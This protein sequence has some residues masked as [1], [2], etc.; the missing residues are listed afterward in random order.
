MAQIHRQENSAEEEPPSS[1]PAAVQ[2]LPES[3]GATSAMRPESNRQTN[4][5]EDRPRGEGPALERQERVEQKPRRRAPH[6]PREPGRVHREHQAD[7]E[8]RAL[9]EAKRSPFPDARREKEKQ[10]RRARAGLQRK[11]P[12][13]ESAMRRRFY[14]VAAAAL[15]LSA[16][17]PT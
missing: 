12:R 15:T 2:P 14:P 11:R 16:I 13:P 6:A 17:C 10:Q 1:A 5:Q 8:R 9:H 7:E 4:P 3:S